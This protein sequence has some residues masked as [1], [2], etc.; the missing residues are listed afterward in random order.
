[1]AIGAM[2]FARNSGLRVP[3]DISFMGFDD[4][5]LAMYFHPSLSTI[6][7]SYFDE[8]EQAAKKL[9]H[10]IDAGIK[11]TGDITYIPHQVIR[12]ASVRRL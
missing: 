6:R 3:D 2:Y 4:S 11:T 1:M 10:L 12:R 7:I 9:F 8:G 5:D